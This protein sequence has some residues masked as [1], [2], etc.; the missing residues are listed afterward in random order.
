MRPASAS[1]TACSAGFTKWRGRSRHRTLRAAIQW[2][3]DLLNPDERRA[4]NVYVAAGFPYARVELL[5]E[6]DT[7]YKTADFITVH[8]AGLTALGHKLVP[9]GDAFTSAAEHTVPPSS[10]PR[11]WVTS[12]HAASGPGS[13]ASRRSRR[14][15]H[16]SWPRGQG[17]AGRSPRGRRYLAPSHFHTG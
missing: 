3:Y 5:P 4:L 16:P 11:F 17:R 2:S 13:A 6:V 12:P 7:L 9:A 8:G 15:D 1:A 14:A 10:H